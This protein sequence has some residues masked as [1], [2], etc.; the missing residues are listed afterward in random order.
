MRVQ[1]WRTETIENI[2]WATQAVVQ[3]T[4]AVP[5]GNGRSVKYHQA[6]SQGFEAG[7]QQV[8]ILFD[9][10]PLSPK[11]WSHEQIQNILQSAQ[12]EM[13]VMAAAS[14]AETQ[15]TDYIR[16]F[17]QGLEAALWCMAISFGL[18]LWAP[19]NGPLSK[20]MLYAT[21]E[22]A[23]WFREDIKNILF[24][25]QAV[26]QATAASSQNMVRLPEYDQGLEAALRVVAQSFGIGLLLPANT[27]S[28]KSD[29]TF[30]RRQD[31]EKKLLAVYK[32]K[33]TTRTTLKEDTPSV[34]YWQGF[35]TA[36]QCIA[37]SFGVRLRLQKLVNPV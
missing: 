1:I 18:N 35:K 9:A 12:V 19:K 4:A 16:G 36:W 32:T 10:M 3:A 31:I 14:A 37:S 34:A 33:P 26:M 2:L 21:A 17:S 23:A 13:E 28:S 20:K 5:K 22:P 30:W 7:L 8:I 6:F 11:I 29:S 27:A 15:S 25:M 24:A